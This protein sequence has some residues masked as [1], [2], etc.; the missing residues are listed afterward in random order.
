MMSVMLDEEAHIFDEELTLTFL[1]SKL[2]DVPCPFLFS[3][4]AGLLQNW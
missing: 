4:N 3:F 2:N 1:S